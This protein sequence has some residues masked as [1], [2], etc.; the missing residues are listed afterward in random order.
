MSTM[1]RGG[2]S[3]WIRGA[4]SIIHEWRMLSES[5]VQTILAGFMLMLA[6]TGYFAWAEMT[7]TE[8]QAVRVYAQAGFNIGVLSDPTRLVSLKDETGQVWLI[9]SDRFAESEMA[10]DALNAMLRGAGV[11]MGWGLGGMVLIIAGLVVFFYVAGRRQSREEYIRGAELG[12]AKNLAKAL[13]DEPGGP[14]VFRIGA[15]T[16]PREFEPQH[17]LFLGASGTGKTQAIYRLLEGVRAAGQRAVVYDINGSFVEKFYREGKDVILNPLDERCPGWTLWDEVRAGTDYDRLAES[18]F[19]EQF[20]SDNFWAF[21]PRTV[22]AAVAKKLMAIADEAG[23]FPTNAE[24]VETLTLMPIDAFAAFCRGTAAAAIIDKDSPKMTGSVRATIAANIK[25]FEWLPDR[26]GA[27]SFSIRQ[28]ITDKE[29]EDA[30]LF[31]TSRNDQLS[32]LRG[33]I[34]LFV[35]TATATL[36]SMSEDHQR[37]TWLV[38]DELTSLN[39]LSAL[40]TMMAQARKFGGCAALGFQSF[41][42]LVEVYK[43]EGAEAVCGNCSTWFLFRPNDPM[44]AKWCSESLGMSEKNEAQEG[45]SV[46]RHEMRDGRTLQRQRVERAVV[47]PS[48]LRN[49]RNLEFYLTLGRDYPIVRQQM[50]YRALPKIAAG[51]VAAA[52]LSA[53]PLGARHEA[54]V[55]RAAAARTSLPPDIELTPEKDEPR[56][57]TQRGRKPKREPAPPSPEDAAEGGAPPK[58]KPALPLDLYEHGNRVRASGGDPHPASERAEG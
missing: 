15:I 37:R 33:L 42:Q 51:Y 23:R 22:F 25:S 34:T 50:R 55:T 7:G 12:Q 32:A 4:Q 49:L 17:M 9:R 39:R 5:I 3:D 20:S 2:L 8:R 24:L 26:Q 41:A 48:E 14:G 47:M 10:R 46:G 43:R 11:G 13:A 35:D 16:L 30:W 28:F 21:A 57:S 40:S 54:A 29:R 44:T 18:L 6:S 19:P 27:A 38:F 36:L 45:L 31:I 56:L 53:N 58:P 52:R 1:F